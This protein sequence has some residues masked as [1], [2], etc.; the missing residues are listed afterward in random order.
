M[1]WG[2]GAAVGLAAYFVLS[3][4]ADSGLPPVAM[5]SGGM[6]VGAAA[7]IILGVVGALPLHATFG[8][9]NLAGHRVSWLVPTVGLSL[10]AAAF[11]YVAGIGAA[12]ILGARLSSFVGLTEVVFAILIAWLALG[13]IPTMIQL[14]GGVLI[15]AG[16]ALVRLDD[17]PSAPQSVE[18]DDNP[19]RT[20][21]RRR[22]GL[23]LASARRDRTD[24]IPASPTKDFSMFT[25]IGEAVVDL[26]EERDGRYAAHPGGSPLN[27][28]V[29]LARLGADVT[30]LARFSTSMFGRRLRAH[31]TASGVNLEHAV[32]ANEPATLAVVSLAED[33]RLSTSS[34]SRLPLIGNGTSAELERLPAQTQILHSGSLACFLDPG[35]EHVA[36]A[37]RRARAAG[38]LVSFDPN[39]RPDLLGPAEE[40][41]LR[42][43]TIVA[44]SDLVKASD[45]DIAWL[46]PDLTPAEVGERWLALGPG[47]SSSHMDPLARS[48]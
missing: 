47:S 40:A 48:P 10:V 18:R 29:G 31:A 45:Q 24:S 12:R 3:A 41:A 14:L 4:R 9:V 44:S 1:L 19:A 17:V 15:V 39:V 16:V 5:A 43:E 25:V 23:G 33:G 30:L 32:D 27:V 2:L 28:A 34:T 20:A 13:E 6:A 11:S 35:A 7:L 21:S 46:Y 36:S 38:V 37:M 8:D 42:I 22:P 26:V